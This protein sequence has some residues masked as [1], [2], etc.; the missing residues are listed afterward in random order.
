MP[1]LGD[2]GGVELNHVDVGIVKMA[3]AIAI[4]ITIIMIMVVMVMVIMSH[5]A[6]MEILIVLKMV[7]LPVLLKISLKV[8]SKMVILKIRRLKATGSFTT[9]EN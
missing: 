8:S 9:L 5:H 4:A 3:K 2:V 6:R 1:S 7:D